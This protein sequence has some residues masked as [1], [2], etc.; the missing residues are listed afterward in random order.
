M[1][2]L[3]LPIFGSSKSLLRTTLG[4]LVLEERD[5]MVLSM[6]MPDPSAGPTPWMLALL[7]P[8]TG[9]TCTEKVPMR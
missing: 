8:G 9:F 4:E 2:W 1:V 6:L 5:R 3:V 7:L